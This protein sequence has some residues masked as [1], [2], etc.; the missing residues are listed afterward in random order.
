MRTCGVPGCKGVLSLPGS[1]VHKL[2]DH[3]PQRGQWIK[4]VPQ[5]NESKVKTP[6]ICA[7]HF[8]PSDYGKNRKYLKP[9]AVPSRHLKLNLRP[10]GSYDANVEENIPGVP[11]SFRQ[12]FSLKIS[13]FRK[14]KRKKLWKFVYILAKQCFSHL[15]II[16]WQKIIILRGV[17]V[18]YNLLEHPAVHYL[19]AYKVQSR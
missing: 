9:S 14:E 19:S 4:A 12:E 16:F 10:E 15:R 2:P 3:Q 18:V 11:I 17:K 13:K 6:S 1:K 8:T 5:L 7:L